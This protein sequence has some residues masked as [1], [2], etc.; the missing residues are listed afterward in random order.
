MKKYIIAVI[1]TLFCS[2]FNGRTQETEIS[3]G[4][5]GGANY[6]T[7]WDRLEVD[8]HEGINYSYKSGVF[9]GG[10]VNFPLSG[11]ITVQPELLFSRR[12]TGI[13]IDGFRFVSPEPTSRYRATRT[14]SVVELP[15]MFRYDA[16]SKIFI[17]AG[18]Q[19]GFLI[20]QK[21][22]VE[23]SPFKT[24]ENL[25]GEFDKFD[26]GLTAGLGVKLTPRLMVNGRY[27]QGLIKRD[28]S[29]STSSLNLAVEYLF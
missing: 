28:N 7:F 24:D 17:E 6:S 20:D 22:E 8:G 5:K 3:W 12:Q 10:L 23:E 14:E 4:A 26:A 19:V 29:V 15:V 21:E 2:I 16:F 27:F 1:T 25:L 9:V 18:P 11:K 13:E